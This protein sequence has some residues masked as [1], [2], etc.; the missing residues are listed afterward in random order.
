M[1]SDMLPGSGSS[2]CPTHKGGV[3]GATA[4]KPIDSSC[5]CVLRAISPRIPQQIVSEPPSNP[6]K[7]RAEPL[8]AV[9]SESGLA[10]PKAALHLDLLSSEPKAYKPAPFSAG[11]SK[12]Q[13]FVS[14][15]TSVTMPDT[16]KASRFFDTEHYPG[17]Q[18]PSFMCSAP[19]S[20]RLHSAHL[21]LLTPRT[22]VVRR[23][24]S[25]PSPARRSASSDSSMF[26]A[27]LPQSTRSPP[28]PPETASSATSSD[29]PD[30]NV[31]EQLARS[32]PPSFA[33]L[34]PHT[35]Q[36]HS[37]PIP[38]PAV[39]AIYT[40]LRPGSEGESHLRTLTDCPPT[41][42]PH[43]HLPISPSYESSTSSPARSSSYAPE[44][45]PE[46]PSVDTPPALQPM[47]EEPETPRGGMTNRESVASGYRGEA[48]SFTVADVS[49]NLRSSHWV[50]VESC[51]LEIDS[52]PETPCGEVVHECGAGLSQ[53]PGV[54]SLS[55]RNISPESLSSKPRR[56]LASIY[57][58]A[59]RPPDSG[60]TR[61]IV[62]PTPRRHIYHSQ[63]ISKNTASSVSHTG[64]SGLVSFVANAAP[65]GFLRQL[66]SPP[67]RPPIPRFPPGPIHIAPFTS[68]PSSGELYEC[69][70][71]PHAAA[72]SPKF[73]LLQGCTLAPSRMR[74]P[75]LPPRQPVDSLSTQ[76]DAPNSHGDADLLGGL[77][78]ALFPTMPDNF[79]ATA[80][81][82][83][84]SRS[85][86]RSRA[87]AAAAAATLRWNS[88]TATSALSNANQ[89][90][91]DS[92]SI[93]LWADDSTADGSARHASLHMAQP[94][95]PRTAQQTGVWP[96]RESE[97]VHGSVGL[98]GGDDLC[99]PG[100]LQRNSPRG[101]RRTL[102]QELITSARGEWPLALTVEASEASSSFSCKSMHGSVLL[103]GS[104]L[105]G[106]ALDGSALL[107]EG[108]GCRVWRKR[109]KHC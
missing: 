36:A 57:Q 78:G 19:P 89:H 1:Q 22:P 82:V 94:E 27:A 64:A 12:R 87:A 50:V 20:P 81:A 44:V 80:T 10:K 108:A 103:D 33:H 61:T 74:T 83:C 65:T 99:V 105:D 101:L 91:M 106:R 53:T 52:P 15:A 47:P 59:S 7:T 39:D 13:S 51:D 29:S 76:F 23:A 58:P 5:S 104:A 40:A 21:S 63:G 49:S 102:S 97:G 9:P 34:S 107:D 71:S 45:P 14:M 8:P 66:A 70:P 35:A 54:S 4:T 42:V 68:N 73:E 85:N 26:Q 100:G 109:D 88:S 38:S 96:P 69:G 31:C 62:P 2:G 24:R 41:C 17:L 55:N 72:R 90:I 46:D 16:P 32:L 77:P 60:R 86:R 75:P 43:L 28:A 30:L 84:R 95:V 25:P 37:L 48:D 11:S 3:D 56:P 93:V 18:L 92:V 67:P 6:Q 79:D 98:G